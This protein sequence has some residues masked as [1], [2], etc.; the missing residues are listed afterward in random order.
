MISREWVDF[1][2]DDLSF[3]EV[4]TYTQEAFE[5]M[6]DDKFEAVKLNGDGFPE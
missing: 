3:D 6:V 1:T 2:I 4:K 5:E